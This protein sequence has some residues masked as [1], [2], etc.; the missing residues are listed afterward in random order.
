MNFSDINK[1][2]HIE[3]RIKQTCRNRLAETDLQKSIYDT[4]FNNLIP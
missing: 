3:S 1:A 4:Q 2:A